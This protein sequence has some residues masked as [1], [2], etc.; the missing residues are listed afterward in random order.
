MPRYFVESDVLCRELGGA[1]DQDSGVHAFGVADRPLHGLHAPETSANDGCELLNLKMI[2]KQGLAFHPV[3]DRDGGEQGAE[4]LTGVFIDCA[5]TGG[6]GTAA[7]IVA[8]DNVKPI[9]V[10][11]LAR[12][13]TDVP[14][15]GFGIVHAVKAGGV[16]IT[17][18]SVADQHRIVAIAVERSIGFVNQLKAMQNPIA[19]QGEIIGMH[20]GCGLDDPY[21]IRWKRAGHGG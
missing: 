7:E 14:P 10:D 4:L 2:G 5:R 8:A 18:K 1:G 19:L 20:E 15:A 6:S 9:G 21:R 16:V 3:I 11:G 12:T 17:G 13:D